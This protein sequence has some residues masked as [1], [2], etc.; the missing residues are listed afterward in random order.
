MDI[1]I[2]EPSTII[3]TASKSL[4]D[5]L[6]L[7]AIGR[8]SESDI[9]SFI[10]E[11]LKKNTLE[12]EAFKYPDDDS[13]E[14]LVEYFKLVVEAEEQ[15]RASAGYYLY[16]QD[17]AAKLSEEL[18]ALEANIHKVA[19]QSKHKQ[20]MM[21]KSAIARAETRLK[22]RDSIAIRTLLAKENGV[23]LPPKPI[24]EPPKEQT[25]QEVIAEAGLQTPQQ[26]D[27]PNVTKPMM[28]QMPKLP[29]K[30]DEP[31]YQK[32]GLFNKKRV[33]AI[34][35]QLK[36]GFVGAMKAYDEER[37]RIER[38]H[39]V[40][41]R[42]YEVDLAQY[43]A[44]MDEYAKA[45]KAYENELAA[46]EE[47]VRKLRKDLMESR[48]IS[49]ER[50]ADQLNELQS[51]YDTTVLALTEHLAENLEDSCRSRIKDNESKLLAY[52]E[53]ERDSLALAKDTLGMLEADASEAK[54]AFLEAVCTLESLYACG[55][56]YPKYRT[57]PIVTTMAEYLETGRCPSLEG[58]D[59]AY[60][61]YESELRANRIIDTLE[62][63]ETSLNEI[64]GNQYLLYTS[65][66]NVAKKVD[67]L[68]DVT[69][70]LRRE[71]IHEA[72]K[73][74]LEM[75]S[76]A[77]AVTKAVDSAMNDAQENI[78]EELKPITFETAAIRRL[79][80]ENLRLAS[81]SKTF[82]GITF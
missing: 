38:E 10:E 36:E 13:H 41:V 52:D 48:E 69:Q 31:Q 72:M 73:T 63:I 64:K 53:A 47:E 80:A 8:H 23:E 46:Y 1:R 15:I 67:D 60:N 49:R 61:L 11:E 74:R 82:F 39:E 20:E 2:E 77:H 62:S 42:K 65:I 12:V 40:Q 24:L 6:L 7:P 30:P 26:P 5:S 22:L 28:P 14:A 34:N 27:S 54:K 45:Q 18:P 35:E 25:L 16:A 58:A 70:A 81:Q 57:Y 71:T 59:G 9:E 33:N 79:T 3:E 37:E 76:A 19:Q 50:Y 78:I 4:E 66:N 32:P 55:R 56:I 68:I 43:Q 21:N 29:D 75:K 17:V 44:T 51:E